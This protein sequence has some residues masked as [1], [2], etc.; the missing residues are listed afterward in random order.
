M[1]QKKGPFTAHSEAQQK[2]YERELRLQY[3]PDSI[4][5]SIKRWNNYTQAQQDSIMAE[6]NQVYVDFVKALEAR[7]G[8]DS[9]MVQG[10]L[11]RW[12]EHLRHFYEPTLDIL[13][14]LGEMYNTHPDFIANFQALHADLPAYLQEVI[15]V[16]VD[17]LETAEI[18]RMLAEDDAMQRRL[19][20][21][22][23]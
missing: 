8:A 2:Q 6:G 13:R 1:S 21:L 18:E 3:G 20:N 22:S 11:D 14:G 19:N 17:D 4:N 7:E 23:L 10:I 16:Y 9:D 15:A 5:P 12:H